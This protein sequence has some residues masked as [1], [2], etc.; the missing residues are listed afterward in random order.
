MIGEEITLGVSNDYDRKEDMF[1][2][3][4]QVTLEKLGSIIPKGWENK[5]LSCAIQVVLQLS[6]IKVRTS[7]TVIIR[8][9]T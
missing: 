3:E 9:T 6:H 2:G 4:M 5:F 7:Y 8:N 1:V